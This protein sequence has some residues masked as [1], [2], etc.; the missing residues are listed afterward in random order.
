MICVRGLKNP[1]EQE[2]KKK[3][4]K[5]L[6]SAAALLFIQAHGCRQKA[7]EARADGARV[8]CGEPSLNVITSAGKTM[9]VFGARVRR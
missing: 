8:A 2:I 4:H 1:Q 5:L 3:K 6:D 7:A 9:G